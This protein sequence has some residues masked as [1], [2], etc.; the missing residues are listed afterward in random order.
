MAVAPRIVVIGVGNES[1]HD[2]GVGR[3]VIERI[4]KRATSRPGPSSR[5]HS[6]EGN[7]LRPGT[8]LETCDGETSSGT[9]LSDP[10][11]ARVD[12]VAHSMREDIV[13]YL[14]DTARGALEDGP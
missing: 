10:D 6:G 9:G 13:R 14:G 4:K 1:R 8:L 11:A 3:A 5:P 7:L 2:D 12:D